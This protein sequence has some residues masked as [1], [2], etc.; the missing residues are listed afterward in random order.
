MMKRSLKKIAV[1][2][3]GAIVEPFE[4][5][6]EQVAFSFFSKLVFAPE[7]VLCF[8]WNSSSHQPPSEGK[9]V[10]GDGQS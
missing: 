7:G 6:H 1:F 10:T 4:V 8:M 5:V 3:G 9:N 2:F